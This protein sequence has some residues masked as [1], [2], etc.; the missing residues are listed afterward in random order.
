MSEGRC[1][2]CGLPLPREPI[3]LQSGDPTRLFCCEGCARVYEVARDTGMLDI[4]LAQTGVAAKKPPVQT[5]PAQVTK[6]TAFFDLNGMWCAGCALAA[7]RVLAN[8]RGVMDVSVS[9]AAEQGRMEYDANQVDAAELLKRLAPLGYRATI[10]SSK[11]K[12]EKERFQNR[13]GLQLIAATAFGMEIMVLYLVQLYPAYSL[14]LYDTVTIRRIQFI[15]W[16]LTTPVVFY[17]GSTFLVG[18][19]RALRARTVGMDTLVALGVLASYSYSAY[20]TITGIGQTYFDSSSMIVNFILIG[21]YLENVGGAQARKDLRSLLRLQPSL[22]WRKSDAGWAQV[23]ADSLVIG[24]TIMVKPGE[25]IPADARIIEG[26]ATLD[27]SMLTGES[28]PVARGTGDPVYA[29]TIIHEGALTASVVLPPGKT[30]LSQIADLVSKTLSQK[31][32][33]QRLADQASTYFALAI[34]F[35]AA[36]TFAGW[37]LRTNSFANALLA[38]VAVLVVACPCALGLATPLSMAVTMGAAA[39]KGILIRSP[40]ALETS[41]SIE[42]F[43]FDKT[44]TLTRGTLSVVDVI[45]L[46][47]TDISR[48]TLLQ[49]A[50]SVEQ[51]SEHPLASAI[52][53]ASSLPLLFATEFVSLRGAGASAKVASDPPQRVSVGSMRFVSIEPESQADKFAAPFASRGNTVVWIALDGTPAGFIALMDVPN[54]TA[55]SALEQLQK[56]GIQ[57]VMLSG[58]TPLAAA[59][60]AKELGMDAYEGSCT[61]EEKAAKIKE[62]QDH[63]E[64]V[65]M[66]GD[67]VNDAPALAQANLSI[68]VAGGSDISGRASDLVLT[69]ADLTLIPWFLDLSKHTRNSILQNLGWA[70]AYNLVAVP[71][72]MIGRISP[73]IAAITMAVSSLIVVLNSLRLRAYH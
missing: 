66:A 38:S 34:I 13:V 7:E 42:K 43:V 65:G 21:R 56:Q 18:A 73:V 51:F 50:A 45:P 40:E 52:V 10:T 20:V 64:A 70:F 53:R 9:F 11:E 72:A 33:I 57:T 30:R 6:E 62:W 39:Q 54:S 71:L 15:V 17:G 25:R 1:D 61:P 58:D 67:G 46:P 69:R 55:S 14:G 29:G 60:I 5:K 3:H 68:T 44:G 27:E 8:N 24:D 47:G 16:A 32:H 37:Y 26:D 22:A 48:D 36:A 63:G 4:V 35:L 2:L 59:S 28:Q 49:I 31:P 12:T 19:W 41:S 23:A